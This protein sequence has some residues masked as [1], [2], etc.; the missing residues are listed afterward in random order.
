MLLVKFGYRPRTGKVPARQFVALHRIF[1]HVPLTHVADQ[2]RAACRQSCVAELTVDALRCWNLKLMHHPA[3]RYLHHNRLSRLSVLYKHD[4][5]SA[6][7]L[8]G[9]NLRTLWG[10]ILP[11][12]LSLLRYF[13]NPVLVSNEHVAVGEQHSVADL[14]TTLRIV[15]F[16]CHLSVLDDVHSLLLTFASIQEV[17]ASKTPV[18]RLLR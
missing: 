2:Q 5:L 18:N 4:M 8:N 16:P 15:P 10:I 11:H 7:G 1:G 14:A 9:V 12:G 6:D 13:S 17:M 3:L